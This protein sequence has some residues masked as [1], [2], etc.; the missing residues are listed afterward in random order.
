MPATQKSIVITEVGKPVSL[1][2]N[3]AI[4][5]PGPN[6]VQVKVAVAGLNAHDA[7]TRD[8]GLFIIPDPA[9]APDGSPDDLDLPF[10]LANDIVGHVTELGPGV[11]DLKV[12][13]RVVYQPSLERGSAQK[14]L[15][16]Y[17]IADL[18]AL[19]KV[20]EGITNDEAATVPTNCVAPLVALFDTLQIPPPWSPAAREFDYAAAKILIIGGGSNTGQF[21]VQLA[22]LATIGTIVVVGGVERRLRSFGA[23]HVISRHLGYEDILKEIHKVVGDDLI[24]AFDAVSPLEG[25]LLALN[26]LS[27]T[28]QGALARLLPLGQVD[29]SRV[30]GKKAGFEVRNVFG[31]SHVHAGLAAEF[32]ARLP[33]Y[34]LEGNIKPLEYV[35]KDGLVAETINEVLDRY[36]DGKP[37]VKTHI[38]I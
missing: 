4:P 27:S 33:G 15:Q 3:R 23:T 38:H 8:Y 24:Y 21:G 7:K 9:T 20:P 22:R 11:T 30:L 6:Q 13:D 5:K 28:K 10:V 35:V 2:T 25:Q 1:V 16:E 32:W 26:A 19:A 29:E 31:S 34:L 17:A 14:G 37:V 36:R 12:G 18:C